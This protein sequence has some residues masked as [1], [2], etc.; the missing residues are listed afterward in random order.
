MTH[1]TLEPPFELNLALKVLMFLVLAKRV[2]MSKSESKS[3]T[4]I[5]KITCPN[6][7]KLRFSSHRGFDLLQ[8]FALGLQNSGLDEQCCQNTDAGKAEVHC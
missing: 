5:V 2:V 3:G 7:A 1:V 6:G 8:S 4:G